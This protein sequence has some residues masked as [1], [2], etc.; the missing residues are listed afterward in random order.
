VY[1]LLYVDNA[2]IGCA[3]RSIMLSLKALINAKFPITD[4]GPIILFLNMHLIRN[5]ACRTI[6]I[7]Q[8]NKIDKLIEEYMPNGKPAKVPADPNIILIKDMC[9]TDPVEI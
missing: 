8:M 4:R 3:T 9:P 1:I 7:H 6:I 2:L 5:R